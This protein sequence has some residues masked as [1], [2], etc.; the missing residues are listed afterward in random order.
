MPPVYAVISFASYRFFREYTYYSLIET[1]MASSLT[2]FLFVSSSLV[3]EARPFFSM[4]SLS[5]SPSY[6]SK[7]IGLSAFL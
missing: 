1:G 7:A 6:K 2:V 4:L 5:L 3:Y